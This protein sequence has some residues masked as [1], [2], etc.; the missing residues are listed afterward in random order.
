MR[1]VIHSFDKEC[2]RSDPHG[3]GIDFEIEEPP[4]PCH[5]TVGLDDGEQP[6]GFT[7]FTERKNGHYF[8][9]V[10]HKPGVNGH[11][12]VVIKVLDRPDLTTGRVLAETRSTGTVRVFVGGSDNGDDLP[13][14]TQM[15][16]LNN[17]YPL[18]RQV[19]ID[20]YP[21][22]YQPGHPEA[23]GDGFLRI[24]GGTPGQPHTYN[25]PL[26]LER[27]AAWMKEAAKRIKAEHPG[28]NVGVARAKSGSANIGGKNP[29]ITTD[30][31]VQG[32]N[33]AHWDC[34]VDSAGDGFPSCSLVDQFWTNP[35][36]GDVTDNWANVKPRFVPASQL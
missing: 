15:E 33:G 12:P 21:Q 8:R 4:I 36:T 5:V 3:H 1:I 14:E 2:N 10:R 17:Q 11:H 16:I 9:G 6:M 24:D 22:L 29:P 31:I 20:L 26:G 7:I 35:E 27:G 30:I 32:D 25:E 23:N 34:Q 13:L 19:R 28:V 18:I